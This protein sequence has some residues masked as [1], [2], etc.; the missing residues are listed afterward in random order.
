M[1]NKL[2]NQLEAKLQTLFE[3]QIVAILPGVSMED[4]IIQKLVAA[5]RQNIIEKQKESIAPSVFTLIVS[6][7]SASKWKESQI[8]N[9]LRIVISMAIKDVGLKLESQPTITITTN[10]SYTEKDVSVIAS[11]KLEP[12][13]ETQGMATDNEKNEGNRDTS[14]K[15]SETRGCSYDANTEWT[16]L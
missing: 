1:N 2:L 7:G 13:E 6:P 10:D 11:H 5:L 12:V 14:K 9:A 3:D 15:Q 16:E 8:M 4:R